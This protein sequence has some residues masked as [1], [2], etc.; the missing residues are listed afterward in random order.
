MDLLVEGVIL[1]QALPN[2]GKW[3]PAGANMAITHTGGGSG[4]L[5]PAVGLIVLLAW[6]ATFSAVGTRCVLRRDV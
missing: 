1:S 5:P 6:V 2:A 3:L 4:V